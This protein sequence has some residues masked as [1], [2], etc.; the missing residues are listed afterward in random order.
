MNALMFTI[1]HPLFAFPCNWLINK[2]GM[3]V[4]FIAGAIFTVAGVWMRLLLQ[5]GN[6]VFCLIGSAFAAIGNIFIL[7]T[8]SKLALNWFKS[9]QVNIVSFTGIL[10][11]LLS[12]TLGASLPGYFINDTSSTADDVKRLLFLEACVITVPYIFLVFFFRDK[13]EHPPSK[14]AKAVANQK[15]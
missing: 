2:K 9:S 5:E 11:N 3:R 8:P 15:P 1:A 4:S 14:S 6:S 12:V 13:P 10:F 7:N